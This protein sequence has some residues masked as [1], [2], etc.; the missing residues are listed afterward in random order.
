VLHIPFAAPHHVRNGPDDVSISMSIIFNT[1]E[2]MRWHHTLEFNHWVRPHVETF[3][4]T[5]TA[6][7]RSQWRDGLKALAWRTMT[8]VSSLRKSA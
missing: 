4:V 8:R 7:A 5:P 2:S 6:A 3:G 1:E